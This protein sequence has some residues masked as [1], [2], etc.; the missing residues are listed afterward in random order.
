IRRE[1]SRFMKKIKEIRFREIGFALQRGVRLDNDIKIKK[2][3]Y[4]ASGGKEIFIEAVNKDDILFGLLR[5]RIE[6]DD[7]KEFN[8]MVRELHVY[9]PALNIGEGEGIEDTTSVQHK[10]LGKEMLQFAEQIAIKNKC[11]SM[12][13][14][15]GVGV[16]E[17][18]KKIGFLLDNEKIYMERHFI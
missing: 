7:K 14:I 6:K 10:G 15:S 4:K 11:K 9:G 8:A 3:V 16:R 18:Y 5:L 12:K 17:Y 13:I 1:G 2:T